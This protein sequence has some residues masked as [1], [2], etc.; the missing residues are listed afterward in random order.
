L[1]LFFDGLPLLR[2]R[3]VVDSRGGRGLIRGLQSQGEQERYESLHRETD[4]QN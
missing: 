4:R 2:E 1:Q 3:V